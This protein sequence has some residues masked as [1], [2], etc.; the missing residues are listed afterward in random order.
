MQA[1]LVVGQVALSLALLVGATLLMESSMRLQ[2]A[3]AGF[4]PDPLLSTRVYIAGDA[5]DGP[6]DRARVVRRIAERFAALPGAVAATAIGAIPSDDGGATTR[7]VPERGAAEAGEE[8]GVQSIPVT[9]D[10]WRALGLALHEGRTFTDSEVEDPAAG[11]AVVNLRL[12]RRFWPDGRA[13]GRR[14]GVVSPERTRWLRIVGV[15]PDLVYEELGE[16]T[17]QS[18]LNVYV[19]YAMLPWRTMAYLVRASGNPA[20]LASGVPRALR[21]VDP[22]FAAY[23]TLTMRDRRVFT[24]WSERFLGRTFAGFAV[25]ALLLASLGVYGLMA[26]AATERT[27]EIGV[28]LA[29]GA[30]GADIVRLLLSRGARIAVLGLGVGLPLAMTTA[31]LVEGLLFEVSPWRATPWIAVPLLLTAAVLA[32]NYLPARRASR[33]DPAEA[34]RRD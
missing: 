1:G 3:D 23:E 25:A 13:V 29:L 19:P 9:A 4:D 30:T 8:L 6:G 24:H 14:I 10:V 31:R 5:Y 27:R 33:T 20:A 2:T 34:L 12:A 28:R 18:R 21:E 26:F 15:A 16:E 32:A 22:A 7:V 17:D 11:V